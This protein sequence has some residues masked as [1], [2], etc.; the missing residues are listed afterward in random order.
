MS[1]LYRAIWNDDRPDICEVGDAEFLRWVRSKGFELDELP[2]TEAKGTTSYGLRAAERLGPAEVIVQRAGVDDSRASRL[3]L[4]EDR[5]DQ[6][7]QWTTTLT[8]IAPVEGH[9]GT[10][11]V[12]VEHVRDDPFS[13]IPFR[14]PRL[15][16][17]LIRS[18]NEEGGCPRV[19]AVPLPQSVKM[20]KGSGLAGLVLNQDRRVALAVFTHDETVGIPGTRARADAAYQALCGVAYVT[21]LDPDGL[22]DF[23]DRVGED[24]MVWGGAAR[25]YLP[26]RGPAG[27]RPDRHRY[28]PWQRI[29]R[30]T[31]AAALEFVQLLAATVPATP[32]PPRWDDL[33]RALRRSSSTDAAELLE[34]ADEEI[35]RL[36]DAAE[37]LREHVASRD[38]EIERLRIE[39]ADLTRQKAATIRRLTQDYGLPA[40]EAGDVELPDEV[41]SIAEALNLAVRLSGVTLHPDAPHDIEKLD[42]HSSSDSWA[43]EVWRG[44]RALDAYALGA[45]GIKGGFAEWCKQTTSRWKWNPTSKKLA[46]TESESVRKNDQMRAARLLPV[47]EAVDPSGRIEMFAHLKIA[48]GGGPLAPRVYFH[49]DTGGRTGKVHVGFVG[50]HEHMPNTRTN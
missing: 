42:S 50:P 33:A 28:I 30:S 14:A 47:D 41:V 12:D 39:N 26:N 8:A 45:E 15:V 25:L 23:N 7:E 20:I 10:L 5:P 22:D 31:D 24:L 43:R 27:L 37:I 21:I 48:E 1:L 44:L 13:R 49:D 35:R 29:Q 4:V 9:G 36:E 34:Y 18:G 46:M 38:D 32:P 17:E 2:E 19:G 6:G 11:W 40:G 16:K 3:R